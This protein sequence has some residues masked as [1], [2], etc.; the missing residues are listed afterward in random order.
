MEEL[1]VLSTA[2]A[3][4]KVYAVANRSFEQFVTRLGIAQQEFDA[5]LTLYVSMMSILDLSPKTMATY[6]SGIRAQ[7]K[8][9]DITI[10]KEFLL[11][12][13]L[14]G[15]KQLNCGPRRVWYPVLVQQLPSIVAWIQTH[16]PG[17]NGDMLC[18]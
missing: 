9:L 1:L 5:Q 11:K 12:R 3:T 10:K 2:L 18:Y 15:A 13:M 8:L 4:C 17:Y 14:K 7:K 6:I 16:Y